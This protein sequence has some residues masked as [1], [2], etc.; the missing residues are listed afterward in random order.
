ML[1]ETIDTGCLNDEDLPWM[2]YAP[3]SDDVQIKYFKIDPV[4][5][6]TISLLKT[7]PGAK[8]ATHHHT[9]TVIVYTVRGS[10]KYLEHDWVAREGSVVYET[11]AT[12]HTPIAVSDSEVVT[13]NVVSGEL[14]YLDE[15]GN[16]AATENWR[17]AMR[18][19]LDH[20]H[21]NGIEPKDLSS[22]SQ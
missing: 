13:F 22:F 18:R 10:W 20:C 3:Y 16:L 12:S 11:A 15:K 19:Y 1:F 8:L 17:T 6:E 2:P 14:L 21:K 4:R 5:G 7:P 9:S